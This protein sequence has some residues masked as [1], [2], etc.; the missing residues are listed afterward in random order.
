MHDDGVIKYDRNMFT[1]SSPLERREYIELEKWREKLFLLALIGEYQTE[2][3]GYGN[4]SQRYNF[5][6][7]FPT[8][9][10]QFII[11]S[12]QTG[13]LPHL[14]GSNYTRVIESDFEKNSISSMGV[15]E[16]SSEA[17]THA[18]VYESSTQVMAVFH[19]HDRAI[20]KGMAKNHFD[21][22][23]EKIEY[24]TL[25]M[26]KEVK[27]IVAN[28]PFGQIVMKGHLDGVIIFAN[29]LDLCGKLTL[30]LF[31]KFHV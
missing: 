15:A 27:R 29:E 11:T 3:I 1:P 30:D 5:Q 23:S 16:A 10:A 2:K 14:N 4:L 13:A 12:S 28:K 26:A 22:T 19:I 25:E 8:K 17:L 9:S 31:N 20:W 18:A 21:S 7:L 6:H 24:G